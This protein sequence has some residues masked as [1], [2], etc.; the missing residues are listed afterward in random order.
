MI[1][2][3]VG[4]YPHTPTR[5]YSNKRFVLVVEVVGCVVEVLVD[6]GYVSGCILELNLLYVEGFYV[7]K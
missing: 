3:L 6:E 2:V 4:S 7:S 5:F 1:L